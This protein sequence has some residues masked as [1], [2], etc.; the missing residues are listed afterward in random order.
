MVLVDETAGFGE[1]DKHATIVHR[2]SP[3]LFVVRV[4]PAVRARLAKLP[5][6]VAVTDRAFTSD[7]S[8]RL[9]EAEALFAAAFAARG[10]SRRR[11][12]DGLEWDATG[13]DPPSPETSSDAAPQGVPDAETDIKDRRNE[14]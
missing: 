5:G 6:V 14:R 9:D 12:S 2:A 13:F 11:A 4:E 10:T 1:I 8:E 3:R 7:V